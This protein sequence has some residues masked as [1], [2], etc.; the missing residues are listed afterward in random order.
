MS[1]PNL[2][3]C[4]VVT[5][6][7]TREAGRLLA[8]FFEAAA[9]RR[10]AD[11]FVETY[12]FS[13]RLRAAADHGWRRGEKFAQRPWLSDATLS[14]AAARWSGRLHLGLGPAYLIWSYTLNIGRYIAITMN[15]TIEPT[16]TIMIGS[17]I[18]VRAL[19]AAST[20]SS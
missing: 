5:A 14:P 6:T 18:E 9:P 15:P 20:C 19:T 11:W 17:R 8:P 13:D 16:T 3:L 7:S 2:S 4:R 12:S 1:I 10:S